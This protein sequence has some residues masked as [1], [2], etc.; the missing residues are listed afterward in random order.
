[1]LH[2]LFDD[3]SLRW[4]C[5]A[6][7]GVVIAIICFWRGKRA[8][9]LGD[10]RYFKKCFDD[11]LGDAHAPDHYD[12]GMHL[13]NLRKIAF[14]EAG[15]KDSHDFRRQAVLAIKRYRQRVFDGY[16]RLVE[17]RNNAEKELH[18]QGTRES[19]MAFRELCRTSEAARKTL[20]RYIEAQE[21]LE[22]SELCSEWERSPRS[23]PPYIMPKAHT[24]YI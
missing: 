18:Q 2:I 12:R 3:P 13:H 6:L 21:A 16:E 22:C 4:I 9:A 10:L 17:L 11:P 19:E 20:D 1:M 14:A 24:D 15:F 8:E 23:T 7:V 5:I